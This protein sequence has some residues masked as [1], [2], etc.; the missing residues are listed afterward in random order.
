MPGW[1]VLKH[2]SRSE[3]RGIQL[4]SER[5]ETLSREPCTNQDLAKLILE[6]HPGS[7]LHKENGKSMYNIV[8]GQGLE[9]ITS[10]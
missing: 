3:S 1:K 8:M 7:L 2:V 10:V 4:R 5:R 9:S 6:Y